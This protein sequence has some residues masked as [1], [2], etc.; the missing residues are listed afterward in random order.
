MK[1]DQKKVTYIIDMKNSRGQYQSFEKTF[2][3]NRHM[4]NWCRK[5][6]QFG[7]KV[8]GEVE[9]TNNS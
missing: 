1:K 4:H 7:C 5:M 8:I 2:N 6:M 3:D 9:I